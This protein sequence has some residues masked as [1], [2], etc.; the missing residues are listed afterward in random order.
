MTKS[1]S[2]IKA[3][4]SMNGPD[5]SSSSTPKSTTGNPLTKS[6]NCSLPEPFLQVNQLDVWQVRER[7]ELFQL[8]RP[9]SVPVI[10]PVSLPGD[11]DFET[12]HNR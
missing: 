6:A 3:A 11:T 2:I 4:V 1:S 10:L 8:Q 12:G 9:N 7:C 5:R